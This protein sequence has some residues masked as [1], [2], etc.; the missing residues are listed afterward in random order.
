[1]E[2]LK[3]YQNDVMLFMGGMCG[4]LALMTVLIRSLPRKPKA[5]LAAME[6]CAMALL[7]FDR[8]AFIYGGDPSTLGF[9]MVRISNAVVYFMALVIPFLVTRYLADLL[10]SKDGPRKLPLQ[11]IIA[12][13]LFCIG[14]VLVVVSL[15][16]DL[17]YYID[18]NN[19]Y[20]RSTW[21]MF[22]Y[23]TP[24]LIIILQE[25]TILRYRKHIKRHLAISMFVCIALP[26]FAS[27]FQIIVSGISLTNM[28]TAIVVVIFYT[29]ALNYLSDVADQAKRHE[30]ELFKQT[31]KTEAAIF[32]QTTEA[33]AN[34]IDAK[35]AY[36]HGHSARV[37][38]YSKQIAKEAGLPAEECDKVYFAALLHDVGKIGVRHEIINKVGK[39]TDEE[40][41]RIKEHPVLGDQIL[42]SIK[43][44]PFLCTGARYHHERYDGKGYP[45][46][47]AGKNIPQ[48]ARIIA[49][50]DAYDAMTSH[51]SYRAPLSDEAVRSELVK[52]IGTQ[53]DPE[54]AKIM[55]RLIDS[56]ALA[57]IKQE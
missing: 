12:D 10:A 27:V 51:R 13:V 14:T 32:E 23:V 53:F 41:A 26:T 6:F 8:F 36:T 39:L 46:G 28:V 20:H 2:L 1:M 42:T 54:Y 34:A 24:L 37:A 7:L 21:H 4:V 55:L 9:Y 43:Q 50:A 35:D 5:I 3:T 16:T 48:I 38:L 30:M 47:L 52:G 17:Y 18:A 49:V 19:N 33:L 11:L 25:W 57:S 15:F 29:H 22:C 44:A 45:D 56:G 40:Y 31:Q